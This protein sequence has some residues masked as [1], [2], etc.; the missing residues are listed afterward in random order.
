MTAKSVT[1]LGAGIVGLTSAH[2]LAEAGYKVHVIETAD[3]PATGASQSNGFQ[4]SYGYLAPPF[5]FWEVARRFKSM[6]CG[7]TPHTT[8]AH[9]K[10]RELIKHWHWFARALWHTMPFNYRKNF[11]EVLKLGQ[12]SQ[13][14]LQA[15]MSGDGKDFKFDYSMQGKLIVE[16]SKKHLFDDWLKAQY[17]TAETGWPSEKF[18]R[19]KCL[20]ALPFL[21][22]APHDIAGGVFSKNNHAGNCAAFCQE[23]VKLLADKYDVTFT[24]NA[25][26]APLSHYAQH[27]DAVVVACGFSAKSVLKGFKTYVPLY[28]VKGY[29]YDFE[30]ITPQQVYLTHKPYG[31]VM[32]DMG[33]TTRV[34]GFA[35]FV[36]LDTS[37]DA[38]RKE[39]LLKKV[40]NLFPNQK[41]K[42]VGEYMA[43][44]PVT[45]NG[46]PIVRR[47][48]KTNVF[49]NTGHGMYGWTL[50]HGTAQKLADLVKKHIS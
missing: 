31:F 22:Q 2:A 11:R 6:L 16:D 20:E 36:G 29:S 27:A 9:V 47:V 48:R 49:I 17:I 25:P 14:N 5:T 18:G 43:F 38:T 37:D 13:F 24:F 28:P 34:A 33:E 46:L 7:T 32:S 40:Q 44:R 26:H 35:D 15:F 19:K 4:L 3:A 23:L 42:V 41:L 12:L 50:A 30:R 39:A 8:I 45:P 21:E 10:R 1:I